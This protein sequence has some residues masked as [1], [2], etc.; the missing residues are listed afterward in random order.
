MFRPRILPASPRRRAV[1]LMV[2]LVLLTL[3]AIVGLAFV[4]YAESESEASRVY[5]EATTSVNRIDINPD[6]LAGYGL[7]QF[8]FGVNDQPLGTTGAAGPF[9]VGPWSA[10][11]GY[12][13][14][15]D[16][17]GWNGDD[18]GSNI[19]PFHGV[20]RMHI[21]LT[22]PSPPFPPGTTIDDHA[23]ISYIPYVNDGF[24]RDPE[25]L[26]YRQDLS[27]PLAPYTGGWN[28][29]YT[30]PDGNHVFLGAYDA[31]GYVLARSF[32]RP[33]LIPANPVPSAA[34]FG[35]PYLPLDPNNPNYWSWTSNTNPSNPADQIPAV[36]QTTLKYYCLRPRNVDMGPGFPLP[37]P[38]GDVKNLTGFP[39]GNDSVWID[40][41][42]PVQQA[43]DGTKWKPLFAFFIVDLDGRVNLN[44][45][46][47]V[48][49]AG[50]AHLS[51][52]GWGPWEINP[53]A[54]SSG[55]PPAQQP[56]QM[57]EWPA[58][59]IGSP[60]ARYGGDKLPGTPPPATASAGKSPH[61]YGAVDYDG[62]NPDGPGGNPT[63]RWSLPGAGQAFP[64]FPGGYGNGSTAERTAHPL[65][66]DSDW[67]QYPFKSD[68]HRF[69]PGNMTALFNGGPNALACPLGQLLPN[70]MGSTRIRNLITTESV[71]FDRP[72]MT[73]WIFDRGA[74]SNAYGYTPGAG[75]KFPPT[76]GAIQFPGFPSRT[77]PVPANSEFRLPGAPNPLPSPPAAP[78]TLNPKID[79]RAVDVTLDSTN[80]ALALSRV[81]L[82][83]FLP[84]YPQ[85]GTG[86]SVATYVPGP[87]ARDTATG[88]P[89]QP[90]DRWDGWPNSTNILNQAQSALAARQQ[91]A[92]DIYRRLLL[93]TGVKPVGTPATPTAADLAP[94]RW[95]AQLAVNIVDYI[96][97]DDISTPFNFYGQLDGL[98]VTSI[99]TTNPLGTVTATG[100][101]VD[102]NPA[103]WVF[104]TEM[105]K[106]LIN[107]VLG[108]YPKPPAAGG[109]FNVNVYVE[110]YNPVPAPPPT[111]GYDPADTAA[112]PLYI[113]A[114][115]GNTGTPYNPYQVV[116]A[117]NNINV[118]VGTPNLPGLALTGTPSPNNN[119]AV[120][121]T[122]N[123]VRNT[124]NLAG[125]A[126]L[127][128]PP[129]PTPPP[130]QIAGGQFF[131]LG[132]S[133]T[134]ANGSI[135]LQT[136]G[137]KGVVPPTP[138][139]APTT[140]LTDPGMSYPV[141]ADAAGNW[142]FG[143]AT[144]SPINDKG[145]GVNVLLRRLSNPRLPYDPNPTI[146]TGTPPAPAPN[147][148]YNPYITVD[149]IGGGVSNGASP[150][151]ALP[152]SVPLNSN[153]G[154]GASTYSTTSKLQPYAAYPTQVQPA[155]L[156]GA[157]PNQT[158]YATWG[159]LNV[160]PPAGSGAPAN[161]L[162]P[163]AANG[164]YNWLVHLDRQLISAMELLHVSGF[165]PYDLTR[166][167]VSPAPG[168]GGVAAAP[169]F[170]YNNRVDWYN[171]QNRLYRIFEYLTT[172]D[173]ATNVSPAG[174]RPGM[175]NINTIYDP[176]VLRALC[177]AQTANGFTT[178]QVDAIFQQML[179]LRSPGLVAPPGSRQITGKD[180]PFLGMG[181]GNAPAADPVMSALDDGSPKGRT[182]GIEDT[183]LRSLNMSGSN[184][185]LNT[186]APRLFDVP[187]V[188]HPYQVKELMTKIYS[189]ITNRSNVFAVWMTVGFFQ[190]TDDTVRPVKLGPEIGAA[191]GTNIRHRIFTVV[192]RSRMMISASVPATT[193]VNA[194]TGQVT[195]LD[196]PT[197]V[198][199]EGTPSTA[200][201]TGAPSIIGFANPNNPVKIPWS[202]Q[203]GAVL[204]I[205]P[206]AQT[207][208]T[209]VVL[210]VSPTAP[211]GLGPG[212]PGKSWVQAQFH[213][214]H[215]PG[216]GINIP[217]NPGP[218][219]TFSV[220]NPGFPG[221]VLG[222]TVLE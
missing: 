57:A 6:S 30:Y 218:Q 72:G 129:P 133:A 148:N 22:L 149:Y 43:A 107:E 45:H 102:N 82:N 101:A 159:S 151:V 61:V 162:A 175:V 117:D 171:E 154:A 105:P 134:D 9:P 213:K 202:I 201:T 150:P 67:P 80:L 26:G 71:A 215:G 216:V 180:Q 81:D 17:F 166:Q 141:T 208:E 8:I 212:L 155:T 44:V 139:N 110:L 156:P 52:Q 19:Y 5:R 1:I 106:I 164:Q 187:G 136:A 219:P 48:R 198:Q 119:D 172:G 176:E 132:P 142:H 42:Y 147:P 203:P 113:A 103:Y 51:N 188:S 191:T 179:K 7:G 131:L 4:L 168:S 123:A 10:M 76:G 122:P 211:P 79:W 15:R 85:H 104:G 174:R 158:T 109:S 24:V 207:E 73:P 165:A 68:D 25:R 127:V 98:P 199:V 126:T 97:E 63:P 56:A 220:T 140:I 100:A 186:E 74:P 197:W 21:P 62:G 11:N 194:P 83:R 95:L 88:A 222:Y 135:A 12:D 32:H 161:M 157:P 200:P 125:T 66:Y 153:D 160:T 221:L 40:L 53:R 41:D 27:K 152:A 144:G 182:T 178:A 99:G 138:P 115:P 96:D 167:F 124:A 23:A 190:V 78:N 69:A 120:L 87:M 193:T 84:P 14:G 90:Y 16:L 205:D 195:G 18:P 111:S 217:G 204:N 50:F 169:V 75:S 209:V 92:N 70:N 192:D 184:P 185:P 47:N 49:G 37:G 214:P 38:G 54:L 91:L 143:P 173:R 121:G 64:N 145:N 39:G 2:V 29:S 3:F 86:T 55:S 181:I 112:V 108:E 36:L 89:L 65:L 206:G 59:F 163:A 196:Q 130:S 93:V 177:D 35:Q 146:M 33:Y 77:G 137:G 34:G 183:F 28:S 114:Q 189:N 20:G 31:D 94:R 13:L 60:T 128:G 116:I 210:A 118:A 58:M 46:G 170:P